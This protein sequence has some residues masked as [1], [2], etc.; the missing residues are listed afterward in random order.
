MAVT[1]RASDL[2]LLLSSENV[3]LLIIMPCMDMFI[4]M[5]RMD[6]FM[7]KKSCCGSVA[8][9]LKISRSR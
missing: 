7:C 5:P 1:K 8:R 2:D 9:G 4:I 3:S 6:M